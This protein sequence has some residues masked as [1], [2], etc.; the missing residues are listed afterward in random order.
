MSNERKPD[1]RVSLYFNLTNACNS[2]CIFCASNSQAVVRHDIPTE[3]VRAA[4]AR[5]N[6]GCGDEISLNGG[7][8]TIHPGLA[9][10]IWEG[11]KSGA[12]VTL[13]TN[14]RS[15]RRFEDAFKVL[16]EGIYRVSIPIHGCTAATHDRM[17]CRPGSLE[18]TLDGIRNV[19]ALRKQTGFPRQIELKLLAIRPIL[20]EWP[21]IIDLIV[22][23]LGRPDRFLLSG[24]IISKSVQARRDELI[25]SLDELRSY[26]NDALRRLQQW[27]VQSLLWS[28]PLCVLDNDNQAAL[29]HTVFDAK[30]SSAL[31]FREIYFDPYYPDGIELR[32]E[33]SVSGSEP[34]GKCPLADMC[35][36]EMP[37]FAEVLAATSRRKTA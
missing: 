5:F 11:V 21:D 6:I 10:I 18:Q 17:T 7:E 28:I 1:E 23:N 35:K 4:F 36:V 20:P 33:K 16:R 37:F 25:P 22:N 9:T 29:Q 8:P 12:Q 2:A 30:P 26:V 14:A 19:F 32:L 31:G 24:L 15:L 27:N 34:C 13:F 3:S